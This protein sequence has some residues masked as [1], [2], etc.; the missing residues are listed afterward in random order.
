MKAGYLKSSPHFFRLVKVTG[1]LATLLFLIAAHL[2]PAP[3]GEGANPAVTP[4]PARSAWFLLWIQE[5]VSWSTLA[6]YPVLVVSLLFLCLPWLPLRR[7]LPRASWFPPEQ[8]WVNRLTL[9]GVLLILALTIVAAFLR[10]ANWQL[11]F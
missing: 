4:N 1:L 3:L 10:G 7:R 9:L 2:V 11:V 5:L 8:R 6:I